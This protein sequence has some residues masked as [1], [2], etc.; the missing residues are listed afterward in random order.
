MSKIFF[1]FNMLTPHPSLLSLSVQCSPLIQ[2][3]LEYFFKIYISMHLY[4]KRK[5]EMGFTHGGV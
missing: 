1:I 3:S 5:K 4:E 2:L